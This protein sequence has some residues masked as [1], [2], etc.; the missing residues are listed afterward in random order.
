MAARTSNKINGMI[1]NTRLSS[2]GVFY[3]STQAYEDSNNDSNID[4]K[5]YLNIFHL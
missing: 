4:P 1:E 5:I 2:K 3:A